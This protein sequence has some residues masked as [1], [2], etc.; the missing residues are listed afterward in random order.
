MYSIK[1]QWIAT[2]GW[3]GYEKPIYAIAGW[4]DTG[5]W[6]DSPCRSNVGQSEA[7]VLK[8]HLRK[9]HVQFRHIVCRS[10]NVFCVHHYLITPVESFKQSLA[11]AREWYENNKS[12][13]YLI[14]AE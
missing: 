11:V 8:K 12:N 14:Y 10:S 7:S 6:E 4:N 9:N 13:T 1:K 5:T 2:D 3:R